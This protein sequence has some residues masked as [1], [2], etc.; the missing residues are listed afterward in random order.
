V[1]LMVSIDSVPDRLVET[2]VRREYFAHKEAHPPRTLQV[3]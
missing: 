3:E 2:T 1:M